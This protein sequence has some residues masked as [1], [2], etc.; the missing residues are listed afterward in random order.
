[1]VVMGESREAQLVEALRTEYRGET[2]DR[3]QADPRN[4]RIVVLLDKLLVLPIVQDW[5]SA[6]REASN[7]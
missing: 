2:R 7:G 3:I 4:E 6:E 5:I 1:M